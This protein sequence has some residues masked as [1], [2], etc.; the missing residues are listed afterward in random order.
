M[1]EKNDLE[2]LKVYN[3]YLTAVNYRLNPSE[4]F[5]LLSGRTH[6]Q[7]GGADFIE[8]TY[9]DVWNNLYCQCEYT[10]LVESY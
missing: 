1:S 6:D 7:K 10:L 8:N 3:A 4:S 5:I 9:M 2:R